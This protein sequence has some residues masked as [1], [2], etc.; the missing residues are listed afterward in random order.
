[1]PEPWPNDPNHDG[2]GPWLGVLFGFGFW[3]ALAAL[4]LAWS[5][6]WH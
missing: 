3:L 5:A 4:L 1:M 2:N 6:W